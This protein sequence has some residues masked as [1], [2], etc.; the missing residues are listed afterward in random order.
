VSVSVSV[1]LSLRVTVYESVYACDSD[2]SF[3]QIVGIESS[4]L[5][6]KHPNRIQPA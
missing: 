6:R 5:L 4:R 2:I 3:R 1:C